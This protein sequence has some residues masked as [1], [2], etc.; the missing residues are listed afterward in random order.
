MKQTRILLI[1][2]DTREAGS[3][4]RLLQTEGYEVVVAN[5]GDEG[6]SRAQAEHFDLVMTDLRMP[7]LD[8][9]N[10]LRQLHTAKPRLPI[11]L[12]TAFGTTSDI[13]EATK[14]GAFE[15]LRKPFKMD[16]FLAVTAKAV[17]SSRLMG[18][19]VA[20]Q[21]APADRDALV[22]SSRVMES[23]Y[24]DIGLVADTTV[25]VL[26]RGE[27]GTGKEL[28]AR[29]IYQHSRRADRPFIAVNCAAIPETLL[30]SELFGHERGSFTG[31]EN[32]HTGRFERAHEGTLFLDEIGDMSPVT[33]TKLLRVLQDGVVQRVGGRQDIPVD[34]RMISATHRDL[35]TAIREGRFREDLYYRLAGVVISL[36]P[37]RE[38]GD[39]DIAHLVKYFAGRYGA[40]LGQTAPKIEPAA[41]RLLQRQ[42]WPGNV[43]QLGNVIRQALLR[44]GNLPVGL[45]HV[46][47]VL[48]G[49][50]QLAGPG[51]TPFNGTV[52]ELLR[53][54]RRGEIQNVQAKVLEAAEFVLYSRVLELSG[55]NQAKAARWLGVARQTVRD[56]WQH[57]GL[58]LPADESEA[59]S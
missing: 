32:R 19:P 27:T 39:D 10:I 53:A 58:R 12:M 6:L 45:H 14:H 36:P 23:V 44:A 26:I 28:V 48:A 1:E 30:E 46:E 20:L 54:A 22:G 7:G 41:L 8:G 33:Q 24:K 59:P 4:A 52:E 38:R 18:E 17:A 34:V 51:Q 43:R 9:L 42:S 13:I 2:D 47:A 25:P 16:E 50:P 31:A 40:E 37:L 35:E 57:F 15:Y 5:R 55:G 11:L 3:L 56:K 29:A 49:A 21:E